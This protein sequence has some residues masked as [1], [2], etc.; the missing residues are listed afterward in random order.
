MGLSQSLGGR[1]LSYKKTLECD[2][3]YY[4]NFGFRQDV[5]IFFK[6]IIIILKN[7]FA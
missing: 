7:I 3:I 6:S 5:K 4:D 1:K 2:E